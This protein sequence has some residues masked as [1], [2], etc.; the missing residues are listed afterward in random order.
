VIAPC[1]QAKT[2]LDKSIKVTVSGVFVEQDVLGAIG[3][4][5]PVGAVTGL[6]WA[7][8]LENKENQEFTTR[9]K[10]KFGKTADVFAM[11][12]YDT[13]RVIVEALNAV[14][15]KT[16]D[17]SA[18]MKAIAQVSFKSPRGDFRFDANSNNVINTL[19]LRKLI[20]NPNL[21]ST[22]KAITSL[23]NVVDPGK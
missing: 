22:T 15:G 7:L 8:T 13:A 21:A 20:P 23:P 16:D 6:H 10:S 11:Q 9:F 14:K 12:G 4:A 17:K 18:F 2:K 1:K 5:A 19:Y 3:D